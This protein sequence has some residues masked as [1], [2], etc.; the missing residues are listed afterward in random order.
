MALVEVKQLMT[1]KDVAQTL[2][3]GLTKVYQLI[4]SGE[5]P[6]VRIGHSLRIVPDQLQASI[7]G[8]AKNEK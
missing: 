2:N 7:T 6:S 8:S 4:A 1:P 3:V 5:I